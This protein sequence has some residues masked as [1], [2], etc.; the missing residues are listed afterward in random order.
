MYQACAAH[1]LVNK[2]RVYLPWE[3]EELG[4]VDVPK[5]SGLYRSFT[6]VVDE[7]DDI[8]VFNVTMVDADGAIRYFARRA[9]FRLINL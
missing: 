9:S 8:I 5:T 6:Q 1:L 2:K 3:V 4:I 7:S